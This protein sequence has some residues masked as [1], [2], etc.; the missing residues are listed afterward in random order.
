MAAWR[1]WLRDVSVEVSQH[2]TAPVLL[3]ARTYQARQWI[4]DHCE[5]EAWQWLGDGLAVEP[6]MLGPIVDG[7]RAAGLKVRV[8]RV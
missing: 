3:R 6:R 8:Y 4:N 1:S 2:G 5:F 7:M